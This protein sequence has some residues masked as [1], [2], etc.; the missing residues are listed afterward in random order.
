[1]S[2][3]PPFTRDEIRGMLIMFGAVALWLVLLGLYAEH[4]IRRSTRAWPPHATP[5]RA[6]R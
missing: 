3:Q 4:E 1:M 5:E 2:H 6:A